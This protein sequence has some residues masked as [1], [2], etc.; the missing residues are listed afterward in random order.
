M[1]GLGYSSTF[2]S[3]SIGSN[4]GKYCRMSQTSSS[5]SSSSVARSFGIIVIVI[6]VPT[7]V[8]KERDITIGIPLVKISISSTMTQQFGFVLECHVVRGDDD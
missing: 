2:G 7:W 3:N 4:I 8:G 6:L 1:N 5:G